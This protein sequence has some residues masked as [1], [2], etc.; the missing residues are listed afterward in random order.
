MDKT[1][2]LKKAPDT[3]L[4]VY[5]TLRPGQMNHHQLSSLAGTWERG[6]VRG[7]LFASGWGAALGF[8]GLILDPLGAV[9]NVELLESADLPQ[10]WE[11]LDEFEGSGYRRVVAMV[12]TEHGELSAWIYVLADEHPPA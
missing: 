5:G 1:A 4:A 6:T 10:H 12:K 3:R 9:V 2:D 8:P 7:K 11:R